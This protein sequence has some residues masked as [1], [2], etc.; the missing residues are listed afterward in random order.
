MLTPDK[1]TKDELITALRQNWAK[2]EQQ[3]AT[4]AAMRNC[5]NCKNY[6]CGLDARLQCENSDY[7]NWQIAE[8]LVSK[9]E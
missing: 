8:R 5:F 4:I 7:S 3:E 1:V 9:G 6:A 2:Q